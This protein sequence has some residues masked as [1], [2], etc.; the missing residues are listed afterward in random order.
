[1]LTRM[2][3]AEYKSEGIFV[4]S[5]HPGWVRTDMGGVNGEV[6]TTESVTGMIKVA[7]SLAVESS[8]LYYAWNGSTLPW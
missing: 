4:V 6:S 1:M 2:L 7:T 5:I 3:G 8:G